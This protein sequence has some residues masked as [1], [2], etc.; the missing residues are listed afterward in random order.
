[1]TAIQ[2]IEELL[3]VLLQM[4][5]DGKVSFQSLAEELEAFQARSSELN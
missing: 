4:L 1:M 2:Y 3:L 5:K